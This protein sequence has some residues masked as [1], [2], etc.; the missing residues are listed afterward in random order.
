MPKN[1]TEIRSFLSLSEY[2]GQFIE[3]FS[4]FASPLRALTG[5]TV[6]FVWTDACQKAFQELKQR[7]T[8]ALIL[9]ISDNV[10]GLVV[11]MDASH[12]GLGCVMMQNRKMVAYGSR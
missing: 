10:V 1:V 4:S 5:K 3:G 12:T 6:K 9:A 7:L 8:S 2:Y 11:Y